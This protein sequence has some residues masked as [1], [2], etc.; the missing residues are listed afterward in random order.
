MHASLFSRL[1]TI[2]ASCASLSSRAAS[3]A[4]RAAEGPVPL[5]IGVGAVAGVE[6]ALVGKGLGRRAEAAVA[7]RAAFFFERAC[8]VRRCKESAVI[9]GTLHNLRVSVG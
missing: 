2:A 3:S 5:C 7:A 1:H 8:G 6:V 4:R 9:L